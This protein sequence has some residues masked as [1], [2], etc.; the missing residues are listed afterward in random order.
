R[1]NVTWSATD[2]GSAWSFA[3]S[4]PTSL[5]NMT[6]LLPKKAYALPLITQGLGSVVITDSTYWLVTALS[7]TSLKFTSAK[8]N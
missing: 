1:L 6:W 5:A 8:V 4:H 3:A 2:T 7:G